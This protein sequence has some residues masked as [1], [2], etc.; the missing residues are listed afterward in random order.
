MTG[1]NFGTVMVLAAS[2]CEPGGGEESRLVGLNCTKV[3]GMLV[4]PFGKHQLNADPSSTAS[5]LVKAQLGIPCDK[6][7]IE[8][9]WKGTL[10]LCPDLGLIVVVT[11]HW[12]RRNVFQDRG[13]MRCRPA[14]RIVS[15]EVVLPLWQNLVLA[16]LQ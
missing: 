6:G 5:M 10:D 15:G 3:Q 1:H 16:Q 13:P 11:A 4:F 9:L 14:R 12:R 2:A 8:D 7:R